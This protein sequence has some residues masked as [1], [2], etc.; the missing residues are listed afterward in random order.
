MATYKA[1][2]LYQRYRRRLRPA[3]H[4]SLGWL[5]RWAALA[6]RAPWL[7]NASLRV[8]PVAAAAKRLGGIDERR[9][10]PA[11]ARQ[12]FRRW[13]TERRTGASQ[14]GASQL[15]PASLVPAST[16]PATGAA[17]SPAPAPW[18]AQA[19]AVVG[20]HVHQRVHARGRPGGG[21]GARGRGLRGTDHAAPGC[22]A[23]SP[24]YRPASSTAPG[25][26]CGERCAR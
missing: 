24:G 22:A 19:R 7:A 13:F 8:R 23:A 17:A 18:P 12:S 20:G 4:Y 16:L 5:P 3:A 10:L 21:H 2:A 25:G 6:A 15:V 11:F 14:P 1:E 26:S 9:P